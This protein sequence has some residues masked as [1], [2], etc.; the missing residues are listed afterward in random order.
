MQSKIRMN[1]KAEFEVARKEGRS[2]RRRTNESPEIRIQCARQS[3][4]LESLKQRL[5]DEQLARAADQDLRRRLRRA[6]DE[7]AAI[8]WATP[9]PLLALPELLVEKMSAAWHQF[10]FQRAIKVRTQT[11]VSLAA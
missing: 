5:L 11:S 1:M 2:V 4:S 9:Y 7:S 8:A 6:A 10:E 3:W